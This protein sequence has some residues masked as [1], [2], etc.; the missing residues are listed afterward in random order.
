MSNGPRF[1]TPRILPADQQE[2]AQ[3]LAIA[4]NPQNA[5]RPSEIAGVPSKFWRPG[6]VLRCRFLDGESTVHAKVE[7]KAQGWSEFANITFSFGDDPDAEIRIS[8]AEV[9][10]WSYIGTDALAVSGGRPT[11]NY[12]W[13]TPNSSDTE[14]NRV[15]LHEFGHAL[16]MI[17]EHQHPEAGIP[18]D[19]DAV[20]AYYTGPPNNWSVA[21]TEHNVLEA[22][23]RDISQY[24]VFDIHSIM[25]YPIPNAHT[26]GDFAVP[27]S[28][29]ELS[30][31]DRS[32]IDRVYPTNVLPFDAAV[33]APND[34]LYIF[35]GP[36]YIRITPGV[37]IDVG[38]PKPIVGNWG[39]WPEE[40][41][42]GI[43]AVMLYTDGKLYFFK[44]SSYLS[45][46]PG[47][48]VDD[49]FPRPI[50]EGWPDMH[51]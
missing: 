29:F 48:G 26:M 14:Y 46:T 39:D 8:F 31:A 18:W 27:W 47:V 32:F 5:P 36:E 30:D 43:D 6:R 15:V 24:S 17:H 37:G 19:R 38:Y 2:L 35:R 40:F 28:N 13:L 22:Y 4:E 50:L 1:C 34:K 49:G 45:Y 33:V 25:L 3:R 23:S 44:G 10:S 12:G 16:G 42:G 11:M 7:E 21:S 9:G 20:L 41:A 51:F